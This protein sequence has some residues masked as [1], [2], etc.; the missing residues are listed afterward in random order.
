MA[1]ET[2]NLRFAY[3]PET[4]KWFARPETEKD[5]EQD[6]YHEF[7]AILGDD[8]VG[9]TDA[10]RVCHFYCA[11]KNADE[12]EKAQKRRAYYSELET[13]LARAVIRKQIRG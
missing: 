12:D 9:R 3:N 10:N 4:G 6:I 13:A 5:K 7:L 1:N 8:I 11:W 2:Q